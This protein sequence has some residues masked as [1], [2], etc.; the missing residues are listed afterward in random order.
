M[1]TT[2]VNA[3]TWSN[4]MTH[5]E[6]IQSLY[7]EQEDTQTA[8]GNIAAVEKHMPQAGALEVLLSRGG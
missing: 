6:R 5:E 4:P 3:A 1:K 2:N 7:P 8:S